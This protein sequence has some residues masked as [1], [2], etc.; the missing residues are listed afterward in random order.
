[1]WAVAPGLENG[2]GRGEEGMGD[3][4]VGVEDDIFPVDCGAIEGG[5]EGM[6]SVDKD[7]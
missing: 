5:D 2:G 7:G 3:L 4:D 6:G 1:M